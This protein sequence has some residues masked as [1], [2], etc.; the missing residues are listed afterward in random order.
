[1]KW[2]DF[3]T[4]A[5]LI[6]LLGFAAGGCRVADGPAELSVGLEGDLLGLDP[7]RHDESV[8]F[9]VMDNIYN[10]LVEFDGR[11]RIVPSLAVSWE[12]PGENVWRF[13]LRPGVRFHN[14][15]PCDAADVK[16]SL[17]RVRGTEMGHYLATVGEV[18]IV[19]GLTV[20]LHTIRPSPVLLNKLTFIAIVPQG[21]PDTI[22]RPVGTGPYR[23]ESLGPDRELVLAANRE[24]WGPKPHF[25][26]VRLGFYE[27]R[28]RRLE[29]LVRG[30]I[31]LARD[32]S[33]AE[34][35][36]DR[37]AADIRLE[38][39]P[40][41]SVGFLGMSLSRP[42]P[43]SKR[44]VRQAIY[45]ALD[46]KAWIE[47]IELDAHPSDQF[48]SPYVVGYLPEHR[49]ERPDLARARKLLARAGYPRGFAATLEV[50]PAAA[51]R[52]APVIVEQLASLGIKTRVRVLSWAGLT[53]R[54]SAGRS[55]FF[56]VGWSC[57]SGD[58]SDFL[59]A[60]LHSPD[61]RQYGSSN[62]GGYRNPEM[63]RLIEQAGS[64]LD[65][66][67]RIELL[68][69]AMA[70]ALEDMPLIPAYARSRTYAHH[71]RLAFVPRLD[72]SLNLAELRWSGGRQP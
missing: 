38:I 56:F 22:V 5:S 58:A 62:W 8:S 19:D 47:R 26:R 55:P 34:L 7:H 10:R 13:H 68:H 48:V 54:M 29:A 51:N 3:A 17:D 50:T 20:E 9:A 36:R 2:S 66:R 16:F 71:R 39:I 40:G 15:T 35:E 41:L 18:R 6:C 14:G 33:Q 31:H 30:D 27:D 21:Q 37:G 59:D 42:G 64:T 43:F 23:F 45:W 61:N 67:R 49:P 46:P 65:N 44:E 24:Y 52:S 53:E 1:M 4:G 72:G 32:I 57:S 60:C 63:D 69:R 28:G 70:L 11:M 25:G 12:N